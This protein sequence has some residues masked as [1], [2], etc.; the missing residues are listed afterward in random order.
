LPVSDVN[1]R[2]LRQILNKLKGKHN[3]ELDVAEY[4]RII[5]QGEKDN[6]KALLASVG[7]MLPQQLLEQEFSY[8]SCNL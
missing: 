5:E 3:K 6:L 8:Y 1:R 4:M 7:E 2:L